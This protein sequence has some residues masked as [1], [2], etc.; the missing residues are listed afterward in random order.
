VT[1]LENSIW[2]CKRNRWNK[3]VVKCTIDANGDKRCAKI[4]SKVQFDKI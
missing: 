4:G 1:N 3:N 2:F